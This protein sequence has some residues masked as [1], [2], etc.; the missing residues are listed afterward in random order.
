MS[1][2]LQ[3]ENLGINDMS[4][5]VVMSLMSLCRLCDLGLRQAQGLS[6][7]PS[8]KIFWFQTILPLQNR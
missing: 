8:H 3:C 2:S 4:H 5:Y 7:L 1:L 6:K